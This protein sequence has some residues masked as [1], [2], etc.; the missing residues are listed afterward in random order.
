VKQKHNF[1]AGEW[2]LIAVGCV[3]LW[4]PVLFKNSN[5]DDI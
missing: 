2:R 1:V 5:P 3:P 4:T